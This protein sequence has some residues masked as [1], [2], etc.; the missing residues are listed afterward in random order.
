[1]RLR[2]VCCRIR[3]PSSSYHLHTTS[4]L[5]V[6]SYVVAYET[7]PW[8][9]PAYSVAFTYTTPPQLELMYIPP[10]STN[11]H[12]CNNHQSLQ[13]HPL[14]LRQRADNDITAPRLYIIGYNRL[15]Q[16]LSVAYHT[17]CRSDKSVR[18]SIA[19]A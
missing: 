16:W 14:H 11:Y 15:S 1:M 4:M 13:S 2:I 8:I 9:V 12:R 3:V 17:P 18:Q 7:Q 6:N 10:Q 19:G 5:S